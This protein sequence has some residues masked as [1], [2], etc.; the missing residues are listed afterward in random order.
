MKL[1]RSPA[2]SGSPPNKC[3]VGRKGVGVHER[4]VCG[5]PVHLWS[6]VLSILLQVATYSHRGLSLTERP[7]F[8]LLH[9]SRPKAPAYLPVTI[10]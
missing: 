8:V 10:L 6:G 7:V 9:S 3:T 5:A 2:T 4:D 1:C